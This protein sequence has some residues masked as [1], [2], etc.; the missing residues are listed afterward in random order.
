MID[1]RGPLHGRRRE[2]QI[3][4][5]SFRQSK[6]IFHDVLAFLG[7]KGRTPGWKLADTANESYLVH[8]DSGA[9]VSAVGLNPNTLHGARPALIL[10]DEPAQWPGHLSE[11]AYAALRTGRGKGKSKMISLGTAPVD[12]AGWFGSALTGPDSM[13]YQAPRDADPFSIATWRRSN[14]SLDF[15]PELLQAIREDA[16]EARRDPA[17]L[18]TFKALRLNQG[19]ADHDQ[20][21]LIDSDTWRAI[22]GD[23]AAVGRPILGLDLGTNAAQSA[24]AAYWP[25][26]GRLEVVAAFPETPSLGERGL[27][28][29]VGTLYADCHRAGELIQAGGN[30]TDIRALLTEARRRWG[31]PSL[32]VCDRWRL[33]ELKDAARAVFRPVPIEERGMGFYHGGEDVRAFRRACLTGAVVPVPSALLVSAMGAA[34][35]VTDQSGNQKLSKNTGGGRRLRARDDAAAASILAVAAGTRRPTT[36]RRLYRGRVA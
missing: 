15:M 29:G 13:I 18:S 9:A 19:V 8:V 12:G 36:G 30:A 31:Q 27:A 28:D 35:V 14:P 25:G 34:R 32:M 3:V 16:A 10:A 20:A 4:S 22:E 23:A 2:V 1:P 5:A 26:S 21:L 17:L 24:A 33:A 7:L 11:R 6:I